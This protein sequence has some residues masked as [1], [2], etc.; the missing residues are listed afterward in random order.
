MFATVE[1]EVSEKD[2]ELA[3]PVS[4]LQTDEEGP[5]V[6][7]ETEPNRFERRDIVIGARGVDRIEI[8]HGIE[9]G[10]TVVV[11]GAF[12]LKSEVAKKGMVV[13]AH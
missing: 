7:V 4:S 9:P 13:H 8:T 1:I 10:E 5:F 3:V 12:I 11:E 2:A 6:F